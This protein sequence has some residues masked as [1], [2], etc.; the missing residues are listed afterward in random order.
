MK[1]YKYEVEQI[2]SECIK[3]IDT[4]IKELGGRGIT[5]SLS[6]GIDSATTLYLCK[7]AV[8]SDRVNALLMPCNMG[9]EGLVTLESETRDGILAAESVAVDYRVIDISEEILRL[10][11]RF[12]VKSNGKALMENANG[13]LVQR[14]RP[15]IQSYLAEQIGFITSGAENYTEWAYD[16]APGI[17]YAHI[18]PI[19]ALFKSAMSEL[20]EY[21]GVPREIITK[22]PHSG[23]VG[24]SSDEEIYGTK[25]EKLDDLY[26][27]W[28]WH[29]KSPG[30]NIRNSKFTS[31]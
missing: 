21:L 5:V 27:L 17:S 13:F 4:R 11:K 18:Y 22:P 15:L 7:N 19:A 26:Y 3:F 9:D 10:I 16:F 14:E 2:A 28:R 24:D 20:A 29:K 12:P 1:S 8:G 31:S 25:I 30:G 23:F 6:G